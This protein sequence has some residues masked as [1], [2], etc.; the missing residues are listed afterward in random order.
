METQGCKIGGEARDLVLPRVG[1]G[2][3][4]DD[5]AGRGAFG[6]LA[7][8]EVGDR[9][10]RLTGAHVV[11]QDA[12]EAEARE[13]GQEVQAAMLVGAQHVLEI[14]GRLDLLDALEGAQAFA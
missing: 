4:R 8:L 12:A 9:L 6:F 11:G 2:G 7:P 13:V 10:E 14:D 3:R 5:K 1:N